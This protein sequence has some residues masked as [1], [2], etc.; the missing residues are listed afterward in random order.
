MLRGA[1]S[2]A[3]KNLVSGINDNIAVQKN[4]QSQTTII[5]KILSA[6]T[7]DDGNFQT[8]KS[9]LVTIVNQGITIRQNNQKI[10]PSGNAAIAGLATV[11]TAQKGELKLAQGLTGTPDIDNPNL[12]NL[13]TMFSGGIKQNQQNA[14][15]V[16][17]QFYFIVLC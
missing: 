14:K 6:N 16:G 1:C 7:T 3:V 10:A 4:E 11:A 8:A 12:S 5:Q 15:D 13:Q 2:T 9:K 17:F